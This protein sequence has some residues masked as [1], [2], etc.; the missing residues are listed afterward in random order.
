[1]KVS[2]VDFSKGAKTL[3][4]KAS[5]TSG[6]AV[7]VCTKLTGDAVAYAEIPAGG[8]TEISVPVTGS[9][10][11]SND[12]YFLFSGDAAFDAWSFS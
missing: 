8:M 3:T 2:G 9:V 6:A 12:L 10:S 11:G 7:K 1:M 4:I 5:S